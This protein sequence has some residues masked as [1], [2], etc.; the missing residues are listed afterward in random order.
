M[1]YCLHSIVHTRKRDS[2]LIIPTRK[3]VRVN[4]KFEFAYPELAFSVY[5]HALRR[6]AGVNR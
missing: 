3:D 1:I 6:L 2:G 4:V 5:Q